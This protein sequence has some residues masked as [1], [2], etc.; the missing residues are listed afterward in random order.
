MHVKQQHISRSARGRPPHGRHV[1]A[2]PCQRDPG[3]WK[4]RSLRGP[5]TLRSRLRLHR[6]V[7][8]AR[9]RPLGR[10]NAALRV[11]SHPR[12]SV[13]S[14]LCGPVPLHPVR[15]DG[16]DNRLAPRGLPPRRRGRLARNGHVVLGAAG[17]LDGVRCAIHHASSAE[18][19]RLFPVA[20]LD[21]SPS[22]RTTATA[23]S[24]HPRVG[25]PA[26]TCAYRSSRTCPDQWLRRRSP[27]R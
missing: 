19:R 11:R 12:T 27:R 6:E 1:D 17:L 18:F 22:S 13:R 14:R 20:V 10:D 9:P 15:R 16:R 8:L 23:A 7:R 3:L 25:L 4:R 21:E 5:G 24:G 26:L 2:R